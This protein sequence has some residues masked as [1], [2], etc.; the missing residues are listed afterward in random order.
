MTWTLYSMEKVHDN[1]QV[2][3]V[4]VVYM[5]ILDCE[6]LKCH[7]NLFLQRDCKYS[8]KHIFVSCAQNTPKLFYKQDCICSSS[9]YS[10]W[11]MPKQT[12]NNQEQAGS[13]LTLPPR[14]V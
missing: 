2:A 12:S 6:Q 7:Y 5:T 8:D 4:G 14:F 11:Q 3:A 13:W 10:P 9:L 1:T